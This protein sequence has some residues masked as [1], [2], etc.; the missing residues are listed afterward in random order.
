MAKKRIPRF[1]R[2][3]ELPGGEPGPQ[4]PEGPRG[5]AGDDG[6]GTEEQYDDIISRLEA[7]EDTE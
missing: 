6:F 1:L 2:G 7:L 4:G 3:I 5:P